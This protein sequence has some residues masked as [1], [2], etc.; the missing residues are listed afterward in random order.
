MTMKMMMMSYDRH[1]LHLYDIILIRLT[2]SILLY[3][4]LNKIL[5]LICTLCNNEGVERVVQN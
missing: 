4:C 2:N 5:F 3:Y 1:E